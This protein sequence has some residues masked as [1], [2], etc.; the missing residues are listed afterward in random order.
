VRKK[1]IW[2][3]VFLFLIAAEGVIVLG[4]ML[5]SPSEAA[6]ARLFGLSTPRLA[7]FGSV[8][9]LS[10]LALG[11]IVL[12][13]RREAW[14]TDLLSRIE[15]KL[16]SRGL[17]ASFLGI[18]AILSWICSQFSL[19]AHAAQEP[20]FQS[21]LLRLLPLLIW[22]AL[23]FG[24][25]SILIL[26]WHFDLVNINPFQSRH[27]KRTLVIIGLMLVVWVW[28]AFSG[29]GFA[30]ETDETGF[31]RAPGTPILGIQVLL[32][33]LITF[34]FIWLWRKLEEKVS[35]SNWNSFI[36]R[37]FLIGVL[38]WGVAFVLWMAVPLEPSWFADEPRLPNNTFSPNSDALVYDSIAHNLLVGSGFWHPDWGT[39]VRR[40]MLS[41]MVAVFHLIGG[42]DYE[43]MIWAQVAF[44]SFF[45]V[46]VFLITSSLHRWTSG[47][48]TALLIIFRERN[49]ILLADTITVSH[50]KVI[51]SDL[52]GALGVVGFV[53]F[54]IWWLKKPA[55]RAVFPLIAGGLLGFFM[56]IRSEVIIL[57]VAIAIPALWLLRRK[58]LLWI[59]GMVLSVL[60][61]TLMIA[62]W[63]WRNY[64]ARSYLYLDKNLNYA[65]II[66][67]IKD[68]FGELDRRNEFLAHNQHYKDASLVRQ[69]N[70]N[71]SNL[72]LGSATFLKDESAEVGFVDNLLNHFFN[73]QTQL[74]LIFPMSPNLL[75]SLGDLVL[76]GGS[77]SFLVFCCDPETYVRSL[78][79]WWSDWDGNLARQSFLSMAIVLIFIAIGFSRIWERQRVLGLIPIVVC[80]IFVITFALNSMSG[81]R[82]LLGA[83]WASMMLFS[84]GLV[85]FAQGVVAWVRPGSRQKLTGVEAEQYADST[86]T[87]GW[88]KYFSV[89]LIVLLIGFVLLYFDQYKPHLSSSDTKF[90][91]FR[92]A[93]RD[94]SFLSVSDISEIENLLSSG[95]TSWYGRATYPRYY[96]SGDGM[97]GKRDAFKRSFSRVEIYL[98]GHPKSTW[99]F[100]PINN[101]PQE[102][103]HAVDVLVIGCDSEDHVDAAAVVINPTDEDSFQGILWRDSSEVG[104]V[105]CLDISN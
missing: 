15:N 25:L 18:L 35:V 9:I 28:L 47:I 20:V 105:E 86:R 21:I 23:G 32:A 70:V 93:L 69:T 2:A 17:T 44:L 30:E 59:K 74:F 14:F 92:A 27:T 34:G 42:L 68:I 80:Y 22:L 66:E 8:L 77:D 4:A 43:G 13:S 102:F 52:P 31:F 62:P 40:P 45:P 100:L 19:Y 88:L 50:A 7:I 38:I 16:K 81:G 11:L 49:S 90:V 65:P 75:V 41:A 60:G 24:Q 55:E 103:P 85:E 67:K 48:L 57:L 72:S 89:S 5:R 95:L 78:P 99:V 97:D 54:V 82:W 79:Y 46:A 29:Y 12:S 63:M 84:V 10:L 26:F 73:S 51:M 87:N 56:L 94:D 98:V 53:L 1:I 76:P 71:D 91:A 3:R 58:P 33:V 83:D 64:Q 61:L 36:R 39:G 101:P 96:Q 37:D 6:S 104:E